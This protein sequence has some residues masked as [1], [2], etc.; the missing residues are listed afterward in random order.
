MKCPECENAFPDNSNFCDACGHALELPCK[1]CGT[2]NR[3]TAKFCLKC[4]ADRTTG[5]P[6]VTSSDQGV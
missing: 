4:G 2:K 3:F 5:K 6:R 1:S